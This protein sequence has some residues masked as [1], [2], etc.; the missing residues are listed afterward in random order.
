MNRM[1]A[2]DFKLVDDAFEALL[3]LAAVHRPGHQRADVQLHDALVEQRRGDVAL[4][5]ALGQPLDDGGLAHAGFADQG[6]VVLGA[7]GKDLD[8]A[9]DLHLAADDRV[10]LAFLRQGGQVG[11]QLVDQRG[12]GLGFASRLGRLGDRGGGGRT[13]LQ[14]APHLAADLVGGHAQP[15]EHFHRRAFRAHQRQE[16]MLGADVVM[17]HLARLFDGVLEHLLGVGSQ[18]DLAALVTP[19]AGDAHHD[20]AHPLRVQAEFAQHTP[21]DA[22]VLFQ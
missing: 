1:A 17:A 22:S 10:Q 16:E 8:D 19:L 14:H 12:L 11:G 18:L 7:P 9:L 15:L 20:L 4:D 3:E 13:F 5:D 2:V 21:G 6:R